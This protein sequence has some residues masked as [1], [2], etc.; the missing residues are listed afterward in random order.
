[1]TLKVFQFIIIHNIDYHENFLHAFDSS[2]YL[3][4]HLFNTFKLNHGDLSIIV[5]YFSQYSY[6]AI[7]SLSNWKYAENIDLL[8]INNSFLYIITINFE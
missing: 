6:D 4:Y 8:I 5:L 2:I 3:F 7:N 1:M